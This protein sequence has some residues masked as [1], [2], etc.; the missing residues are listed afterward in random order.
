MCQ[1]V[2]AIDIEPAARLKEARIRAGFETA[3]DA[4]RRHRWACPTYLAHENASRGFGKATATKYA[5][6][7]KVSA[8]W[9]LTGEV[10]QLN[11]LQRRFLAAL[12]RLPPS[13]QVE[14]LAVLEARISQL[15]QSPVPDE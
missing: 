5:K 15:Q 6:A 11:D 7:F 13:R 9:L 8:S 1:M 14:E 12:D 10:V 2:K 3:T 4:A